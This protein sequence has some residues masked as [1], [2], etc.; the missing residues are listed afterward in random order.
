MRR[1]PETEA[2]LS[3]G[4]HFFRSRRTRSQMLPVEANIR[5]TQSATSPSLRNL[6]HLEQLLIVLPRG[7]REPA[8]RS[9][10][11]SKQLAALLKKAGPSHHLTSVS[12]RLATRAHTSVS[13]GLLDPGADQ[14]E[15]L[16]ACRKLLSATLAADPANVGLV[17]RGFD[18]DENEALTQALVAALMVQNFR[19]PTFK[20]DPPQDPRLRL[21]RIYERS[22]RIDLSATLAT[23]RGT[24]LAR[25]LTALPPNELDASRYRKSI[26][27]LADQHGWEMQF[28]DE[29]KLKRRGAG[30]FLA[31]AQGNAEPGAGIVHLRYRPAGRKR[32]RPDLALIGKGIIFDTGGTNLKPHR[33]MLRMHED[34]QG[35][36][37][38]LGTLSALSELQVDFSIDCWLA[39]TENRIGP[40][41]YKPQD[42]VTAANGTTIQVIHTDAEGRMAL[43]DTLALAGATRPAFML[44]FATLTGTCVSALTTRFSGVFSNRSALHE[45]LVKAGY[46]SG[47]RVWPFPMNADFDEEL[48]SETADI[49]QCSVAGGGDHILAARFL[50]KFVP[51]DCPWVHVD[52]SAGNRKGGLAHVPTEITGFGVGFALNL[53]L[54]Q[55][56][57]PAQ[58]AARVARA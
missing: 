9:L 41:A 34:M 50:S 10:P 16:N 1:A 42:V 43:A 4:F 20:S 37:V 5:I 30:A 15:R 27:A 17:L 35:S 53:L 2:P 39:L 49:M 8:W 26:A 23:A 6:A 38:A 28:L 13:I 44:D 33:S 47:E 51:E 55:A 54:S 11:G 22:D 58:L 45:T 56:D 21:L 52:L 19:V 46:A 24:N 36:A 57:G 14:F 7:C 3:S 31:V 48:R 12:T 29:A 18:A 40:M 32:A 25:W